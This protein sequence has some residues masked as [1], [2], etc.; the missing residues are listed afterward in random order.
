MKVAGFVIRPQGGLKGDF[1]EILL[2]V[3]ASMDGEAYNIYFYSYCPDTDEFYQF[4]PAA[5][6]PLSNAD[7]DHMEP[8]L[9]YDLLEQQIGGEPI[10][11]GVIYTGAQLEGDP[12]E[13][14]P[15]LEAAGSLYVAVL[16]NTF[17]FG[18]DYSEEDPMYIAC[19]DAMEIDGMECYLFEVGGSFDSKIYAVNYNYGNQNVYEVSGGE[20]RLLGSIP[21]LSK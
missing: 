5:V 17:S 6:M 2:E 9:Y 11:D 13:N 14:M 8:P 4:N 21:D 7:M 1:T 18:S 15:P 20:S 12:G 19:V 3:D 16:K 10:A